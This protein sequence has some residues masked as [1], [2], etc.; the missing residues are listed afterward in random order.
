MLE[1]IRHIQ[2]SDPA[3]PTVFE[4]ILA[5]SGFHA[6]GMHRVSH[7]LWGMKLKAL[8]RL[9]AHLCRFFTGIEIH[10]GAVIGKNLFIDHGMGVV[11]GE[12]SVIGD[13][14]TMYHGVTLGGKGGSEKPV[15]RHPTIR[16]DVIIGSGAQVLGN[17]VIAKGAKVGANAVVIGDVPEGCTVVGNPA[18]L[19]KREKND[20]GKA[21]GMPA[22]LIDPVSE[23]ID[24]LLADVKIL[25]EKAGIQ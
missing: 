6:V 4:V 23:A 7:F 15:K 11:I 18:R 25:K 2:K 5:Y 12:T 3:R 21:Y 24:E 19:V 16:D 9:W 13:N 1:L 17:I 10:P 20:K 22:H 14:V 8:A